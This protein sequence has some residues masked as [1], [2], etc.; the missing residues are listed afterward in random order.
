M[1]IGQIKSTLVPAD[2]VI[3][4]YEQIRAGQQLGVP[5]GVSS[6][7][8]V[9]DMDEYNDAQ[10]IKQ[11]LA[12]A[13][14]MMITSPM[15]IASGA[16]AVTEFERVEPGMIYHLSP[17]E[18]VKFG[19]PPSVENF[20]EFSRTILQSVA[21]GFGTTYENLTGDLNNVNFSSG[22]MGW[23]EHHR[24]IEDWQ[25]NILIPQLC[26]PIWKWF[27]EARELRNTTVNATAEWVPP[28]RE[29]IDPVKEVKA[30]TEAV[31][32][33]LISPQDAIL[34]QGYDPNQVLEEFKDWNAKLD[35]AKI[36]LASDPRQDIKQTGT[37]AGRPADT[38]ENQDDNEDDPN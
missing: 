11:K 31:R 23:I 25:Y 12:A 16:D 34:E 35:A 8:R 30:L 19:N 21:A 15:D 24:N 22:R 10:V 5:F 9:R 20:G 28:R 27:L 7:M 37:G 2:S 14:S 3:H 17:G 29:M 13:Y 32:A 4:V 26:Q 33:G 18:D 38:G 6:F 36:V 1:N